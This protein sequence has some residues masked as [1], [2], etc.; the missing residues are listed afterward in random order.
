[1][2]DRGRLVQH[3]THADLLATA[4][5]YADLYSIHANA[6]ATDQIPSEPG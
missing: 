2:L 1:V 4:G 5:R 6:Y 3:G